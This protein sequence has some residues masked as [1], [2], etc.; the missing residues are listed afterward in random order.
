MKY[1]IETDSL[2]SVKVPQNKYWGA[3][4]ERCQK[5]FN[6]GD[7]PMPMAL[8][9]AFGI[10]KKACALVNFELGFLSQVKARAITQSC[11]EI[12]NGILDQ[13]FPLSVWQT[14]S[15]TQTHMN[16]NE[17]IANR[18]IELLGGVK[19]SK[20]PIHPNDDVN[21]GQSSNDSFPTAMHIAAINQSNTLLLPALKVLKNTLY[22]YSKSFSHI[23]KIGRT[24][25]QDATPM[26]LGQEFSS[27]AFQVDQ[28]IEKIRLCQDG[29]LEIAQG[30]TAVGTGLNANPEFGV[31]VAEKLFELTGY[32]FRSSP[33]KFAA[34]ASHDVFVWASGAHRSLAAILLKLAN[35]IKLLSSGPYCGL[36][37]LILSPNEPG[38]SIMPGKI[39]PTQCE[40]LSQV[41]VQIFGFDLAISFA[42]SQGQLQLNVFKPIIIYNYLESIKLLADAIYSFVDHGLK[43]VRV[44]E[45][46]LRQNVESSQMLA[47]ALSPHIGYDRAAIIVK[48]AHENRITIKDAA[49]L[50]GWVTRDDF[51]RWVDPGKMAEPT[52]IPP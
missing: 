3:Q 16:V 50:S 25:L 35:D 10:Q 1:R 45:L 12:I 28:N 14:G 13:H 18:A 29:F 24:H 6:I 47:T 26:T 40:A 5:Y 49:L 9:H 32:R 17:V 36:G 19:G 42:G 34:I 15:G 2:G 7:D 4:T 41:C 22:N 37:E 23:L 38:S 52:L 44:N 30:G 8:I 39:N 21:R 31:R 43:D 51:D 33:N 46:Q 48:S 27:F 11:D 20:M